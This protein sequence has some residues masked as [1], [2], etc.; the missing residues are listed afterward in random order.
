[1]YI[2]QQCVCFWAINSKKFHFRSFSLF[3]Q[4]ENKIHQSVSQ[5]VFDTFCFHFAWILCTAGWL[6][7]RLFS[8]MV[9]PLRNYFLERMYVCVCVCVCVCLF[10]C[11]EGKWL[12]G[13]L[14]LRQ[15]LY[16]HKKTSKSILKTHKVL[17]KVYTLLC[18]V[19]WN[20]HNCDCLSK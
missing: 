12:E 15:Y 14:H 16:L 11:G 3:I 4:N 10:V 7:T 1:M 2:L 9:T 5:L 17:Y 19:C 6:R 20:V 8:L 18:R 13:Y